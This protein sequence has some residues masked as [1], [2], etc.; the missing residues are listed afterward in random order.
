MLFPTI[1]LEKICQL[2]GITRQAYYDY[3]GRSISRGLIDEHILNMVN[4]IRKIHPR[5]GCRKIHEL[6]KP[7]LA[8]QGIKFGRD[9]LFQLLSDNQML[10]RRRKRRAY[11]TNS[12]HHFKKY[13]NLISTFE[14]YGP[15]QLWVSDITYIKIQDK[16]YYLFLITDSYSK[17]IVGYKV[18]TSLEAEHAI[19]CLE[20]A[21]KTNKVTGLIHHSDRGIQYCSKNYVKLLQDYDVQIS[22][23]EDGNPL[24]NPVAERMNGILKEEYIEPLLKSSK[25]PIVQV[26]DEAVYRYN[27]LRPHLSCD[28]LTPTQAHLKQGRM[29]KRW[30]NYY[31]LTTQPIQ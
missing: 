10:I 9:K 29:I 24:H 4:S 14:P 18:S 8:Q 11:T 6:L 15:N 22:M 17:K 21:F 13:K 26:V 20:M 1:G 2:F 12:Y 31:K 5:M 16:F 30:K 19:A 28:M 25:D 3:I 27:Q 23:T 7:D